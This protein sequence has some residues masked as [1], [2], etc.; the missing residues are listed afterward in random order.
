[1]AA[2]LIADLEIT[3]DRGFEEYR[4]RV[5]AVIAAHGGRYLVRGGA[6]EVLE[7][8]FTPHRTVIVEFPSMAALRAFY[9]SP[10][11][12][13][14]ARD[15]RGVGEVDFDRDRR[16]VVISCDPHYL[17][18]PSSAMGRFT[19]DEI[20]DALAAHLPTGREPRASAAGHDVRRRL[21]Y[22]GRPLGGREAVRG[23]DLSELAEARAARFFARSRTRRSRFLQCSATSRCRAPRGR[24]AGS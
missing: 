20:P 24:R 7:G 13:A 10:E 1:M 8:T 16:R 22:G 4:R 21:R 15:T 14:A 23:S 17:A 3:D 12:R 5:P 18:T 6:T 2:Y 9:A 19:L 11:Y